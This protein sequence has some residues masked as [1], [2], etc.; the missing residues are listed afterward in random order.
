MGGL[1][2]QA[3]RRLLADAGVAMHKAR[4]ETET[5]RSKLLRRGE[6]DCD[7]DR[8]LGTRH[9]ETDFEACD[10]LYGCTP[11]PGKIFH[12]CGLLVRPQLR[13]HDATTRLSGAWMCLE[14]SPGVPAAAH[15]WRVQKPGAKERQCHDMPLPKIKTSRRFLRAALLADHGA[16]CQ[17]GA[18]LTP[19]YGGSRL[20][21]AQAL[22]ENTRSISD[23]SWDTL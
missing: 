6:K 1:G 15:S 21:R 20:P 11:V 8:A 16:R 23:V 18:W 14:G 17:P 3:V 12:L 9:F 19:S 22:N 5:R 10:P 7:G 4:G 13:R 2:L